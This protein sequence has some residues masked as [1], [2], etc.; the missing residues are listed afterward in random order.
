MSQSVHLNRRDFLKAGA[1]VGGGIIIGF[2]LP[3]LR[4]PVQA[5]SSST[6]TPNAFIRIDSDDS[7]T[8]LVNKS[9][10]GQGVYTALPMIV[11]EELEAD[12]KKIRVEAASVAPVYNHT[13]FGIQVTGGSTSVWSSW[14]QLRQAGAAAKAMLIEA[15]A[16]MWEVEPKTCHAEN[17]FVIHDGTGQRIPYGQLVKRASLLKT[18]EKVE[19][20]DPKDFQLIGKAI[21]RID[22]PE[23]TYGTAV[24]GID[25]KR[26]GLLTAVVAR[27][28]VFGAR[29]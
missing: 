17:G 10:M 15:A 5:E 3:P 6:F 26:R 21:P 22:T 24:F 28:P 20:K 1:A 9:E 2:C 18:P 12:W 23:K 8:I 13:V 7:V 25:V 27:P 4:P 11:A 16:A 19:L 29:V 14:D